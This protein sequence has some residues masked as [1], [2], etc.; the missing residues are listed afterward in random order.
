MDDLARHVVDIDIY[1]TEE[2][3]A[4]Y[5]NGLFWHTDHYLEAHT[6]AH[7]TFTRHNET[8]STPGQ[9]GGGP[10]SEHCYTTGLLYHY[11]M[12]GAPASRDAVL[13]LA[14]WMRTSHEGQGGLLEQLLALKKHDLPNL[15]AL[16]KGERPS[17]HQY[18]FTRGTGNY[19]NALL[20]AS[21]LEPGEDWLEH[22][23]GVIRKTI[24]PADNIEKRDLLEV[25]TG[26][27]YLI[28]MTSIA[29][30]LYLKREAGETDSHY[31]YT[32]L[33]FI[34]Y[35]N[36]IRENERP[37][38][39][40][41]G[42]LEFPN[43]TWVAQD[44]RKAMLMFQA[45]ELDLARAEDYQD[46]G[47]QWLADVCETLAQGKQKHYARILII[48]MQNY[49]PQQVRSREGLAQLTDD[50][51]PANDSRPPSLSWGELAAR[52]T[53]RLFRGILGFRPAKERAW[54]Y[55]RLDRS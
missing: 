47:N 25:E 52:I 38:L 30:Y 22:A 48:L 19:L 21:L 28:L 35:A 13:Q 46:K 53:H 54:L 34:H 14:S 5:N 1:H 26:W 36:W 43:D 42:Q 50:P 41:P 39:S 29:R 44:V 45:A 17:P 24:H 7:R 37:F 23:E 6:A 3:R 51:T 9:T 18:P 10:A 49:G 32:R 27:S 20:D 12:T 11:Y 40:D 4:E 55:A 31:N 15:K 8:S 33:A 16:L 2:D